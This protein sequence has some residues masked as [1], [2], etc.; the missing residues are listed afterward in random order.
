MPEAELADDPVWAD[1][2]GTWQES[3]NTDA[4]EYGG[5]GQGNFGQVEA[6]PVPWHRRALSLSLALPPLAAV[7]FKAL[8]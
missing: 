7:F 6:A 5:S 4:V 2:A 1:L 3:V 8:A